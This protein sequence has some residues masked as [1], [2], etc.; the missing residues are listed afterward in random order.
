MKAAYYCFGVVLFLS[1]LALL[2]NGLSFAGDSSPN[3]KTTPEI[4]AT[5]INFEAPVIDGDLDDSIWNDP[6]IEFARNFTQKEPDEG[7]ASTESTLV[8]VA[9]DDHA[10]YFALWNFDSQPDR[11]RRQLVRRDREGGS[12][13]VAVCLD[14]YHDHQTGCLFFVSAAGVQRDGQLYNDDNQDNSWDGVWNS[15]V[16]LQSW[17]WSAEM[18]IPYHC[19]RFSE[20]EEHVWGL[21]FARHISRK[22][23]DDWWAFFPSSEGGL[24]S[25]FGHLTGLSGIKPAT[26]L[27]ILPYVVSGFE[28][29][30]KSAGNPDGE[31]LSGN[32]GFDAKYALSSNLILDATFNPD[33]GQVELDRPVLNLSTFET[34]YPEKRPFFVEGADLFDTRFDLF[35]SRRIGRSPAGDVEDENFDDYDAHF[36]Y[37]TNYPRSTTILGAAKLTG[38]LGGG[39]SIA[40][41]SAVTQRETAE[42]VDTFG[43]SREVVVEPE[44]NYSVLRVQ[45]DV[46]SN[47]NFG[48][49]LTFAGQDQRHPAATGGVDWRLTTSDG[50]WSARGQTVFSHVDDEYTGFGLDAQF[51]KDAGKHICGAVG[52]QIRDPHLD[53][54]HLGYLSRN[55]WRKGWAQVQYRSS[56]DW[57]I[58]RNSWNNLDYR[59]GWNYAGDNIEHGWNFNTSIEFLNNWSLSGGIAQDFCNYDDRETRGK[60][61]WEVPRSWGWWASF[62]TDERKK[63]SLNL[64]PGGGQ[65]RNGSW[66]AHWTGIEYRPKSNMEFSAGVNYKRYFD[67]TRWVENRADS[68]IFADLDQDEVWLSATASIM[69]HRNLSWQISGEGLVSSLNYENYR[70]Y[71]QGRD[72]GPIGGVEDYDGNYSAL[73]STMV[74]RWEYRPGS[75]LYFVWTRSRSE[76][77]DAVDDLDLSRDLDRLFSSGANNVW[78]IKVSYWWNI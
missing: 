57:W 64:N 22:R 37:Y 13:E 45:Q 72:Y 38:K 23:E 26:H 39:T 56:E 5:R 68:A 66:W 47:S 12:D 28:K 18:R 77:D 30:P 10:L 1:L 73:N 40:L 44:A 70:R 24:V 49:M 7:M 43:V 4:R 31:D 14:P 6:R 62:T 32:T 34:F 76:F 41:L 59:A 50:V 16:K 54:N 58:I 67:Q 53:L 19:L 55:D 11:I 25:H 27:E 33:F 61:L 48:G 46:F 17:G 36:D 15:A 3:E 42:Y 69:L 8:A 29:E 35:Y 74:V 2:S 51:G 21:D 52:V 75:T 20:K 60:G 63:V 65:S 71:L 9:Y 78:L